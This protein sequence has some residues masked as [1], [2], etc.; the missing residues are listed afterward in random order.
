MAA[1]MALAATPATTAITNALPAHK[2]GVASA[3][4]DTSREVGSALGVAIVGAALNSKYRD[5]ML[6]AVKDLPENL[7]N[8][9][10]NSVAFTSMNPPAG[11]EAE[12]A[13]LKRLAFESF[14][15][16]ISFSLKLVAA[17]ALFGAFLIF[18][19][20]PKHSE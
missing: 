4:N 15:S 16:G 9:I 8:H 13:E 10:T 2:Q 19:I 5:A 12:F 17:V 14:L 7:A 1:G 20:A 18:T 6:P 11:K 3:V